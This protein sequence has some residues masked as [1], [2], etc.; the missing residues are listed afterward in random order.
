MPASGYESLSGEEIRTDLPATSTCASELAM[1]AGYGAAR[2]RARR[3][4]RSGVDGAL[5][6]GGAHEASG[7]AGSSD[8][9]AGDRARDDQPLDLAGAFEDGVDLAVPVPALDRMLPAVSG[10][11]EDLHRLL[12]HRDRDLSGLQLRHRALPRGEGALV[13]AHPRGPP[14]QH[15]GA[16]DLGAHVREGERDRLVLR[17]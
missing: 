15:P 13:A 3:K 1:L 2:A 16:V 17:D 10:A 4:R 5:S 6:G 14:D 8:R 12:G 7:R 9:L 11:A